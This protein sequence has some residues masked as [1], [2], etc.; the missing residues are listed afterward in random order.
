LKYAIGTTGFTMI[1]RATGR[2]CAIFN[3]IVALTFA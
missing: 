3:E 1:L 2:I